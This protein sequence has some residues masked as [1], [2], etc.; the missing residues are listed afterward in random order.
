MGWFLKAQETLAYLKEEEEY[1]KSKSVLI[2]ELWE[3]YLCLRYYQSE[4]ECIAV[5][6]LDESNFSVSKQFFWSTKL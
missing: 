3:G 4:R 1:Q 2:S 5:R 6:K